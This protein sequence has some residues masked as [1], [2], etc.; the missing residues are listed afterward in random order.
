ML[1]RYSPI[2]CEVMSQ[3]TFAK[4]NQLFQLMELSGH[5]V[6]DLLPAFPGMSISQVTQVLVDNRFGSRR[7]VERFGYLG[8]RQCSSQYF[9][10]DENGR[11][12][13]RHESTSS[14][15][16]YQI[17]CYGG[18]TTL[19]QNVADNQTISN[20]LELQLRQGRNEE[21]TVSNYGAGN[22]TSLHSSLRLLDHALSGRA[23]DCA[24][25]LNGYN[26]CFFAAGGADGIVPFL[27][28]VLGKSQ[29]LLLRDSRLIE[30]IGNIPTNLTNLMSLNDGDGYTDEFLL[31]NLRKRYLAAIAIQT[32]V[33]KYFEVKILRFI[34]PTSFN[35]CRSDQY[36]LPKVGLAS[37]RLK[38]VERLY[39]IINDEGCAKSF[40]TKKIISLIDLGQEFMKF[41]L[42]ID[43]AHFSPRFNEVIAQ[44]ILASMNLSRN[45]KSYG[46][47]KV[48][49][50]ESKG[51]IG[52]VVEQFNYPLF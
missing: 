13:N 45:K 22:H 41:P 23:P 38:L 26:D 50:K 20:Y 27:D 19:G 31:E 14:N 25:F 9:N 17:H 52:E 42:F 12:L 3:D 43:E 36:L 40:G 37:E 48:D 18:S 2:N 21:I 46:R 5:T 16:G 39:R 10:V 29:D 47:K 1:S 30:L 33:E 8:T 24:I 6:A 28:E 34:E 35:H 32:F 44:K 51:S 15:S 7:S 49:I 4:Q 11:R